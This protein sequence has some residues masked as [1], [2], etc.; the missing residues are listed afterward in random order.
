MTEVARAMGI[1]D[2]PTN[3]ST[4]GSEVTEVIARES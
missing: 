3:L 1:G 2:E 4:N